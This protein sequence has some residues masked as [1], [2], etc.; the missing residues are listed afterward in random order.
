MLLG[1]AVAGSAAT[2]SAQDR[3]RAR[4]AAP[5]ALS[6]PADHG[7]HPG[8]RTEWW[9]V[10][11]IVSDDAGNA[12]GYQFTIFR[13]ELDLAP[14]RQDD[15]P[16]RLRAGVVMPAHIAIADLSRNRFLTAERVRR[17]GGGLAGAEAGRLHAWVESWEIEQ[18]ADGGL[19]IFAGDLVRGIGLDL[20]LVPER[21]PV[22]HGEGGYSRK[23]DDPANASAYVSITRLRTEGTLRIV[24]RDDRAEGGGAPIPVRGTSWFDHEW[25][26]SQL[27]PGVAGWD[28]FSLRLA[29][30]RDLMLYRLR[31]AD[32]SPSPWSAGTL[33]RSD[34]SAAHLRAADFTLEPLDSWHSPVTGADYP[35]RWRVNVAGEDLAL[36][37]NA[38]LPAC[39]VDA[40]HSTGLAYWEGPVR[41]TGAAQG[42]GYGEFTGYDEALGARF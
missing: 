40:R 10:T 37:V 20:E 42:E 17:A 41:V 26:T 27:D 8:H 33:V 24:E 13:Q 31:L 12:Y 19:R 15:P 36:E 28:W 25:G 7:A 11:G 21:P 35:V 18:G 22:L 23:G 1:L 9:Y 5:P 38:F 29:D 6:F 3:P 2:G 4:V 14:P 30:G 39:E 16:S 32:G 34:G